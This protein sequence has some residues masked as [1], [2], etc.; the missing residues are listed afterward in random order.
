MP[1]IPYYRQWCTTCKDYTLFSPKLGE[2]ME[3]TTCDSKHEE[4]ELSEIPKDKA[5]EQRKRYTQEVE[6]SFNMSRLLLGSSN[7]LDSMMGEGGW[8]ERRVIEADAGQKEID[9]VYR[10]EAQK[11]YV[12]RQ[13]I[14]AEKLEEAKKFKTLLRNDPC[15]CGSGVKYKK[16]CLT[17]IK[18]VK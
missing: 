8:Q 11:E 14:R 12:I 16:C 18:A 15:A 6:K 7:P 3:C 17:R 1:D 4:V 10:K 2:T 13:K 9:E 5:Q